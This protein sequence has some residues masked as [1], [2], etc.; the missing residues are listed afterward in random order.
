DLHRPPAGGGVMSPSRDADVML[1]QVR[2]GGLL[3]AG[4]PVLA[5]LSGGRDSTCLLDLAVRI[6]GVE[7]VGALHVNYGLRDEAEGDERHCAELCAR[8]GVGLEVRR[9]RRVGGLQSR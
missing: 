6:S 9:P 3:A 8:L 4:R 2:T 1:E 5:L 7:A